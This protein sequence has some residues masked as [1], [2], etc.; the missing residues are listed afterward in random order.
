MDKEQ[1][2]AVLRN[3]A[4]ELQPLGI[5]HL[6]LHGSQVN[7]HARPDS[8]IDLAASFDRT[9]VRTVL[10]EVALRNRMVEILGTDVDL[11]DAERLE[12]EVQGTFRREAELVF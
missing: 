8:D 6:H 2:K 12:A 1:I 7:G 9:K 3:R 11:C 5:V 4:G 10:D